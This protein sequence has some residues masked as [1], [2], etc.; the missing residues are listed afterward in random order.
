MSSLLAG[1]ALMGPGHLKSDSSG[2]IGRSFSYDTVRG[3][4]GGSSGWLCLPCLQPSSLYWFGSLEFLSASFLAGCSVT[5]ICWVAAYTSSS[6]I[7]YLFARWNRSSI[8]VGGFL[9][10]DLKNGV[11]G[12]MLRLKIWRTTSML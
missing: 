9:A 12:H 8:V 3:V 4:S 7:E 1:S 2:I 6:S 11:L 10:S 5:R